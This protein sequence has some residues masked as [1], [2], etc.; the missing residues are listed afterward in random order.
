MLNLSGSDLDTV[1]PP[2]QYL[3]NL[4]HVNLSIYGISSSLL[5]FVSFPALQSIT[6]VAAYEK[7]EGLPLYYLSQL[8]A[9]LKEHFAFDKRTSFRYF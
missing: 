8:E 5:F 1:P 9:P 7:W 3:S 4:Q 2:L 6:L